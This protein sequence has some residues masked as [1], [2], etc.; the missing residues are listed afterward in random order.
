MKKRYRAA[1]EQGR[2]GV[3]TGETS[4]QKRR[5]AKVT[6]KL[7]NTRARAIPETH[8]NTAHGLDANTAE[9]G[10]AGREPVQMAPIARSEDAAGGME[11]ERL[12]VAQPE[13]TVLIRVGGGEQHPVAAQQGLQLQIRKEQK[14]LEKAN[15]RP[16][17]EVMRLAP[18]G[19]ASIGEAPKLDAFVT[20]GRSNS[21]AISRHA[22]AMRVWLSKNVSKKG[23][24]KRTMVRPGARTTD[25]D[26]C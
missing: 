3:G 20:E 24:Q 7:H 5:Q 17:R 11:A 26:T 8:A 6:T 15:S 1:A 19:T 13:T 16:R 21:E 2:S 14:L 10:A 23:I 4:V 25:S 18:V 22:E 12:P 9:I